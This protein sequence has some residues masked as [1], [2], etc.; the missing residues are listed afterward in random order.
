MR[1]SAVVFLAALGIGLVL[2]CSRVWSDDR[3]IIVIREDDCCS[4][5]RTPFTEFGLVSGLDYLKQNQIPVTW[6]VITDYVAANDP[7]SLSWSELIDYLGT[8]GGELASHS[9]SHVAMPGNQAY[10]DEIVGSRAA[11]EARI[12][13]YHCASFIQP[14]TWT[15]DAYMNQFS[16]LNNAIGLAIQ[17]TY[18]QSD[19]YLVGGWP[20]GTPFYKYGTSVS[21]TLDYSPTI[22]SAKVLALLDMVAQTP[23]L[24]YEVTFHNVQE[25]GGTTV[26]AVQADV[27]K[28][29]VDKLVD[30]RNQ[31]RVRLMSMNDAIHT[32]FSAGLNLVTDPGFEMSQSSFGNDGAWHTNAHSSFQ[33]TGGVNNSRYGRTTGWG[34]NGSVLLAPGRYRI[35]WSQKP[36]PNSSASHKLAVNLLSYSPDGTRID[37]MAFPSYGNSNPDAWERQSALFVMEYGFARVF[38]QFVPVGDGNGYGVDDLSIVAEPVDAAVSPSGSQAVISPTSV[39]IGWDTPNDPAVTSVCI[40]YGSKVHP[41]TPTE[42]TAWGVVPAQPGTHQHFLADVTWGEHSYMFFSIFAV[43]EDGSYSPP[44]LIDIHTDQSAPA[45][46][47]VSASLQNN[48]VSASWIPNGTTPVYSYR[49]AVGTAPG[50]G[51]LL[52]WTST[53]GTSAT[54]SIPSNTA[55]KLFFSVRNE[56]SFGFWSATGSVQFVF[57]GSIVDAGPAPDSSTI[58]TIGIVTAV[59]SDCLYIEQSNRVRGIKIVGVHGYPEGSLLSLTGTISTV[60]GE[61]VITVSPP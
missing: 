46:P 37:R 7:R 36:E 35:S 51:D 31:G 61:R 52:P 57:G 58:S 38:L 44:D 21:L 8:A 16:K 54:V 49:Y 39:D 28:S 5:L 33:N 45:P 15:K 23:G 12:P 19:A 24:I 60:N 41:T 48:T 47:T 10:I 22:S 30:L 29:F 26:Y 43:K 59:F 11:I 1:R 20:I 34:L 18:E 50:Q 9:A 13:G 56:S 40:R 53:S 25:A 6:A 55:G 17:S 32:T 3:P 14:G 2:L 42:G 4:S 27:L